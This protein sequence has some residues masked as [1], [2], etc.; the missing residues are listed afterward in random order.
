MRIFE[1]KIFYVLQSECVGISGEK[2]RPLRPQ[3]GYQRTRPHHCRAILKKIIVLEVARRWV[4]G[5]GVGDVERR[6]SRR[7]SIK[8][9]LMGFTFFL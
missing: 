8:S 9:I 6:L 4:R 2:R 5:S 3:E 1:A 7:L